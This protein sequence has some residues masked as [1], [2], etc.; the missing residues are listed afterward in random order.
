MVCKYGKDT[1]NVAQYA[2]DQK[3]YVHRF[4]LKFVIIEFIIYGL[5]Y[6]ADIFK[7][8]LIRGIWHGPYGFVDKICKGDGFCKFA[9]LNHAIEGDE[10]DEGGLDPV[11]EHFAGQSVY[12]DIQR[13]NV[14]FGVKRRND[15]H[16]ADFANIMI[17]VRYLLHVPLL[18]IFVTII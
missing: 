17:V 10:I 8:R 14:S 11:R 9:H 16:D 2:D 1:P 3:E 13:F 6:K 18:C 12:T 15:G 5:R 7:N 4:P